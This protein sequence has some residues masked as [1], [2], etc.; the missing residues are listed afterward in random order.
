MAL[1]L[2]YIT[3]GVILIVVLVLVVYL[4]GIIVHLRRANR[5]LY[6]LAD[7]LDRIRQDTQPLE[8]KLTT[9]NGALSSL[10]EGL[11]AVNGHLG[12]V[13]ALLKR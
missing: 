6:E 7:G 11:S 12:A 3:L 13:A 8:G 10:L 5:S 4:V 2:G 1:L 9:I